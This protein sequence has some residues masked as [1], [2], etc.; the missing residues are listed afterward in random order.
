MRE[1]PPE[2]T[3]LF[4]EYRSKK[5]RLVK[6]EVTRHALIRFRQR[7]AR[8]LNPDNPI[9]LELMRANDPQFLEIMKRH[10]ATCERQTRGGHIQRRSKRYAGGTI[11]LTN[12]ALRF[13][14]SNARLVTVESVTP[15]NNK[16]KRMKTT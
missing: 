10:L 14:S 13:V 6:C 1:Q 7:Y 5:N 15:E 16:Q 8:H 12:G 3:G 9:R 11:F 4:V 2:S